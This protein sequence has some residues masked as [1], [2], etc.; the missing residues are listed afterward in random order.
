MQ[1]ADRKATL[2]GV[3]AVQATATGRTEKPVLM[4]LWGAHE[5]VWWTWPD[6]PTE[7]WAVATLAPERR[8]E[9]GYPQQRLRIEVWSRDEHRYYLTQWLN[10]PTDAWTSRATA[11]RSL[12]GVPAA[13]A[14]GLSG[15]PAGSGANPYGALPF[16]FV[17]DE[18]PVS[19]FAEGG[20]GTPL[21]E[22]NAEVDREL[23]N[24][25]GHVDEF[26][27]PDRFTV[28]V[29]PIWRR[30]KNR[31][32]WQT[33]T[34]SAALREGD[35]GGEPN[36]F[37]VQGQLAVQDVW[38]NAITYANSTLEELD[39]PL[40]AVR[41]DL[42]TEPSG[43]SIVARHMPLFNRTRQRQVP[44]SRTEAEIAAVVLAVGGYASGDLILAVTAR[45][46]R[47][48]TVWPEPSFPLPS[49]ERSAED[50]KDLQAGYKSQVQIAAERNGSTRD[51]AKE[52]L[53]QV[54]EDNQWYA[55]LLAEKGLTQPDPVTAAADANQ[56]QA[57][58]QNPKPGATPPADPADEGLT[59]DE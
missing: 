58:T 47:L 2:N 18:L 8:I 5:F 45:E 27:D 4:S 28:G 1:Q 51:Q 42:S 55:E 49:V 26:M 19:D 46:A 56:T 44:F 17:H 16:A 13:F 48:A 35:Q 10:T 34:P 39:I 37:L 7:V 59:D 24:L 11:Y 25:A 57:Q 36:A 41:A 54:L 29:N 21:R 50:E 40:V 22:C 3:C 6:D 38:F 15:E 20:I 52:H 12:F 32:R 53:A 31:A 14:P 23:S 9:R 43:I 30:E 33:L